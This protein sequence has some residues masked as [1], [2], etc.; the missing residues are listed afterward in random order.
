MATKKELK[1]FE[2]V[3]K[4]RFS[5][6]CEWMDEIVHFERFKGK[7]VL[8]IGCG[9]GYDAYQFCR[10]GAV[11]IQGID[12]TPDNPVIAKKHLSYFNYEA[13]FF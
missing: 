7:K 6:E 11:Y 4:R 13:K 9:A 5:E 12:L 1:N 10:N 3:L 8:E 2:S